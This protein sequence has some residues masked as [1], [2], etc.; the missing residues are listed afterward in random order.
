MTDDIALRLKPN[1]D[2]QRIKKCDLTLFGGRLTDTHTAL[3]DI[4]E[5]WR[6]HFNP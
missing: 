6:K 4:V 2:L 3:N 1:E 5:F